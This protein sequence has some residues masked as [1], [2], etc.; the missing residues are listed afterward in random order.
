MSQ[1]NFLRPFIQFWESIDVTLKLRVALIDYGSANLKSVLGA[2]SGEGLEVRVVNS[3]KELLTSKFDFMVLPGVGHFTHG[4][5][6]LQQKN[7][8]TGIQDSFSNGTKIIGIC[9]GMHLLFDKSAE[10]LGSGLGMLKG[11]VT[12]VSK[13]EIPKSNS[14]INTGWFETE[15]KLQSGGKDLSGY[16]YFTHSY[17]LE[18]KDFLN[19]QE[20]Q[21]LS[22]I[23][24]STT[25][26]HFKTRQIVG[27]QFHPERSHNQGRVF[28]NQLISGW[29]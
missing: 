25:V 11:K 20:L 6:S 12:Q 5:F 26:S 7:L 15:S 10:G 4:A 14:R 21:E 27:I 22:V 28:I 29:L 3:H 18:S 19:Q 8:M 23:K 17:G 16:Y 1:T 13:H 24:D 2:I 9:L